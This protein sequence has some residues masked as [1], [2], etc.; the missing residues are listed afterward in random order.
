[1]F[2]WAP[3]I[4]LGVIPT[5]DV[6]MRIFGIPALQKGKCRFC[7]Q[8]QNVENL[9]SEQNFQNTN[10]KSNVVHTCKDSAKPVSPTNNFR[11]T[12]SLGVTWKVC[13]KKLAVPPVGRSCSAASALH[14][15]HSL[16]PS[17][18]SVSSSISTSVSVSVSC[19]RR[20]LPLILSFFISFS[21]LLGLIF[22]I[23]LV[24]IL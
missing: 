14:P 6:L 2:N 23:N 13:G 24:R 5:T 8:N 11:K 16:S 19:L 7:L 17:P 3:P 9:K 12:N 21:F 15:S 10:I 4:P 1:M 18:V 20:P 22:F